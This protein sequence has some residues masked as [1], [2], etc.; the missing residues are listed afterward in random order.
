MLTRQ[1][2]IRFTLHICVKAITHLYRYL[3]DIK[4]EY[5]RSI[6]VFILSKKKRVT[7]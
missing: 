7:L 6:Y 2:H 1:N 4:N 3:L 5:L